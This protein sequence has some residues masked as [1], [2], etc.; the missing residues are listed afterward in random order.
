[1]NRNQQYKTDQIA[2]FYSRHRVRYDQFYKSERWVFEHLGRPFGRVLD[3]G[4]AAGG[5][6]LA[7]AERFPIV[8]Y[9]GVDI[10]QQAIDAAKGRNGGYP[11][12]AAF[13][14]GDITKIAVPGES[15]DTVI[16]LGCADWNDDVIGNLEACWKR[17]APGGVFIIS[18]RLTDGKGICDKDVSYQ[19]IDFDG[20]GGNVENAIY[21]VFNVKETLA[22]FENLTPRASHVLAYGY[23]GEPSPTAVT[24]Y[25]K[26]VF[27]VFAVTKAA[28]EARELTRELHL[29]TELLAG[30]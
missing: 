11:M 13:E 5:L 2:K 26:L 20:T 6:G 4:C 14:C 30:A 22:R 19:P 12:P 24:P 1:M 10:N 18:L 8:S 9:A 7:L 17:V 23:W 28:G 21:T 29:P 3:V 25:K 27:T 16:S 15:F